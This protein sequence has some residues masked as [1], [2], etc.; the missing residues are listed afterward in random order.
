MFDI[1]VLQPEDLGGYK[2]LIDACFGGSNEME[3]YQKY[4][5]NE[6][7][8]IDVVKNGHEIIG[9]VTQYAVELFTFGFQPCLM[10]FNVAVKPEYRKQNIGTFM[11]R[12]VIETAKEEGYRSISLTCLEDAHPAHRLYESVGFQRTGS[13]KYHL[14]L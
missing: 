12:H 14:D 7:Y 11:L 9:S 8:R 10:L 4:R 3:Q 2:E 13:V 6:S 5:A 1:E